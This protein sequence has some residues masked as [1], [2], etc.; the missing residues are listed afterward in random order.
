MRIE[1]N[2]YS[3]SPLRKTKQNKNNMRSDYSMVGL[4][5]EKDQLVVILDLWNPSP[6]SRCQFQDFIRIGHKFTFIIMHLR[7]LEFLFVGDLTALNIFVASLVLSISL[8]LFSDGNHFYID[9]S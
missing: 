3:T 1:K 8:T 2:I 5:L 7:I 9:F 6:E 4:P